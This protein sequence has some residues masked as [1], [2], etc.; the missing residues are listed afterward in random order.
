ME[1]M[2]K[3]GYW[4]IWNR[5]SGLDYN[6]SLRRKALLILVTD[7]EEYAAMVKPVLNDAGLDVRVVNCERDAYC[8]TACITPDLILVDRCVKGGESSEVMERLKNQPHLG[9]IPVYMARQPDPFKHGLSLNS[10]QKAC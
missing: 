7:D 10:V 4:S 6:L 5:S 8:L 1:A 3:S 2:R 9:R